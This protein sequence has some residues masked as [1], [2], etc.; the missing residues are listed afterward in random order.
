MFWYKH[1]CCCFFCSLTLGEAIGEGAFGRVYKGYAMGLK[2]GSE[3]TI[4]AVK[5]LKG[6]SKLL[7][8]LTGIQF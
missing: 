7:T 1:C 2:G 6:A 8:L 4:L 3:L 5:M